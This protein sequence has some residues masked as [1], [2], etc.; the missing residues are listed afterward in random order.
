MGESTCRAIF[1][2]LPIYAAGNATFNLRGLMEIAMERCATARCAI[3]MMGDLAVRYG[4]YGAAA[5]SD[6]PINQQ[7][8]AGEAL[9][10]TD[11]TETWVFH[12]LPDDTGTSAI[13]VAQR[14]P[15]DHI[16]AIAN[17]FIITTPNLT[18]T[19]NFMGSANMYSVAERNNLWSRDS[20][21]PFNFAQVRICTPIPIYSH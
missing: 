6:S 9:T 1:W 4:F 15:D 12:I 11:T 14:V 5:P 13:W 16:T 8:E 18:D 10:V 3:I 20:G 17:Q 7:N 19:N 2:A 21:V